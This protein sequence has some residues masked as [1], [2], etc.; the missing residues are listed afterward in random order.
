MLIRW[1]NTAR[2]RSLPKQSFQVLNECHLWKNF[3]LCLS[4]I[5]V[6]S[7]TNSLCHG[8]GI[9]SQ[10]HPRSLGWPAVMSASSN[11]LGGWWFLNNKT[12][13]THWPENLHTGTKD[14]EGLCI[15]LRSR[16]SCQ[17]G[18]TRHAY[19]WQI[20]P[21]WQDTLEMFEPVWMSSYA[22][23]V[24]TENNYVPTHREAPDSRYATNCHLLI[25]LTKTHCLL[26]HVPHCNAPLLLL[27]MSVW[28]TN[29]IYVKHVIEEYSRSA[30]MFNVKIVKVDR[31]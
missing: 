1:G 2:L 5:N 22:Y 19:T 16:V 27:L 13:E 9:H 14:V 26:L 21:F 3:C 28:W 10:F 15:S 18:P 30:I 4:N 8:D 11:F 6:I 17:K 29:M 23:I 31:I 24:T 7:I 12:L 20:G 25:V